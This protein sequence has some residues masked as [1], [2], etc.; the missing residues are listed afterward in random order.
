MTIHPSAVDWRKALPNAF[1]AVTGSDSRIGSTYFGAD[2][3]WHCWVA[4]EGFGPFKTERQAQIAAE[5]FVSS[6]Y[7]DRP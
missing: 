5:R 1:G 3:G 6:G 4:G 7:E 2:G